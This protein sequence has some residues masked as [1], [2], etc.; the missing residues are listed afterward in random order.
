MCF[1][2]ICPDPKWQVLPGFFYAVYNVASSQSSQ[3]G[4]EAVVTEAGGDRLLPL[5]QDA[6]FPKQRLFKSR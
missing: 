6:S 4:D 1:E 3:H 2:L 5:I